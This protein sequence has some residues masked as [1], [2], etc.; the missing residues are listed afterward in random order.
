MS[1]KP[2][3]YSRQSKSKSRNF[4]ARMG[5]V[6]YNVAWRRRSWSRG[7]KSHFLQALASKP[8]TGG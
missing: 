2:Q 7:T 3:T 6:T 4:E 1:I 5:N 8:E